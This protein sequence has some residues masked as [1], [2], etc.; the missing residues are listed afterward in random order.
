MTPED[1]TKKA[2]QE[3]ETSSEKASPPLAAELSKES[4]RDGG[5]Y[6]PVFDALVTPD[7][8][9]GGLVAYAIYKQNK[10]AWLNDFIKSS[11]RS[12][13]EAEVRAD[14]IGESTERRLMTYRHLAVVAL[15]GEPL[16]TL[17]QSSSWRGRL[18]PG[19]R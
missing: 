9:V 10:R 17:P 19:P 7:G 4:S 5:E 11:G 16:E 15:N 14:I 13:T 18:F 3:G 12:P 8:E 1:E 2:V 6:S